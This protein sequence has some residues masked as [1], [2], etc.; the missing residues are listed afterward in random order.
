MPCDHDTPDQDEKIDLVEC[1]H[2]RGNGKKE[3]VTVEIQHRLRLRDSAQ[4]GCYAVCPGKE[5]SMIVARLGSFHALQTYLTKISWTCT[6]EQCQG[7]TVIELLIDYIAWLHFSGRDN[8]ERHDDTAVHLIKKLRAALRTVQRA[9]PTII[10]GK[11]RW[12]RSRVLS[13]VGLPASLALDCAVQLIFPDTVRDMLALRRC[14]LMNAEEEPTAFL[15]WWC[16]L[17]VSP[18][19]FDS[20]RNRL[21]YLTSLRILAR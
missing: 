3:D 10:P 11:L 6:Q 17:S 7:T 1:A 21:S 4:A 20:E 13:V 9:T 18:E 12:K 8:N 2:E 19:V 15:S 14:R 5:D 16:T